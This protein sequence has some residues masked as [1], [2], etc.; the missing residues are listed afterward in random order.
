MLCAEPKI[1]LA[2][3][4]SLLSTLKSDD[5]EFSACL[6]CIGFDDTARAFV[7]SAGLRAVDELLELGPCQWTALFPHAVRYKPKAADGEEQGNV[8]YTSVLK[9]QALRAWAENWGC[10]SPQIS[11]MKILSAL[12]CVIVR[13]Q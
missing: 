8:P 1:L 13:Y 7:E 10:S 6:E 9:L 12:G 2:S 11:G 4:L 5:D 3:S